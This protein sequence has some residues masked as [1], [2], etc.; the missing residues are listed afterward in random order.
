MCEKKLYFQDKIKPPCLGGFLLHLRH[1]MLCLLKRGKRMAFKEVEYFINDVGAAIIYD[2]GSRGYA[3]ERRITM[4]P[5][6]YRCRL[7]H[8]SNLAGA[9]KRFGQVKGILTAMQTRRNKAK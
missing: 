9:M 7:Y 3:I 5:G 2:E 4:S 8:S 1:R 6:I